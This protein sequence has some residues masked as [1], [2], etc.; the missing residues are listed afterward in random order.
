MI[1]CAQMIII[2][3]ICI[4]GV[5][6]LLSGVI[7]PNN[8]VVAQTRGSVLYC[9]TPNTECCGPSVSGEWYLP[10]GTAVSSST[11]PFSTSQV[12]S[13]VSLLQ[14][15]GAPPNGVYRCEIPDV[16]GTRLNIYIGI[17]VGED[18]QCVIMCTRTRTRTHARTRT[19]TRTLIMCTV[20]CRF[21]LNSKCDI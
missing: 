2:M 18:V 12:P 7:Y 19:H 4:P 13:A 21:S 3:L 11:T 6:F 16:S 9:L 8:S 17:G 20:S 1:L 5:G 10:N 15:S 14:G